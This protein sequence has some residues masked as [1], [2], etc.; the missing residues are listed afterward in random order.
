MKM[1]FIIVGA[2]SVGLKTARVLSE[3]GNQVTVVARDEDTEAIAN[4]AISVVRSD[5]PL[6]EGLE[7][8][9]IDDADALGALS[10]DLNTNFAACMI[11][12]QAGCRTVMRYD[13][14]FGEDIY[15]EHAEAVDELVH[16]ERLS[17]VAVTNAIVGGNVEAIADVKQDLQLVEYTLSASSPMCGYSLSELEFPSDAR[18]LAYSRPDEHHRLP[19][20]DDILTADD[21]LVV[22]TDFRKIDAVRRLL[23][24]DTETRVLKR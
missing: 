2:G 24:G 18:L 1:H 3:S 20:E 13:E 5:G 15:R 19:S 22:L 7:R 17:S 12:K 11:G 14:A 6:A 8:A 9:G 4:T 16:P 23:V 10:D 21:Q